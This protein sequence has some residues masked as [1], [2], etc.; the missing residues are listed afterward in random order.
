MAAGGV[1]NLR[2]L[3]PAC[4]GQ[5]LPVR[6]ERHARCRDVERKHL[7]AAG[8]VPNLRRLVRTC[9]GQPLPVRAERHA[10]DYICMPAEREQ[11]EV[12][13]AFQIAPF[14]M[15][16]V[17]GAGI[18][19]PLRLAHFSGKPFLMGQCDP[20]NIQVTLGLLLL[21]F[22]HSLLSLRL[23]FLLFGTLLFCSGIGCLNVSPCGVGIGP[24][25]VGSRHRGILLRFHGKAARN[26]DTHN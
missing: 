17:G 5:P 11:I 18:E 13:E 12:A 25:G 3:V 1:P 6:T 14:P 9:R 15:A 4:R 23:A 16:E 2:R 7:V 8:G 21:P 10:F 26:D 19:R 24:C 22:G 20:R